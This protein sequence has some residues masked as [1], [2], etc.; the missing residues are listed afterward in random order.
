MKRN[1]YFV[2]K[3][4]DIVLFKDAIGDLNHG[5]LLFDA[6]WEMGLLWYVKGFYD[7]ESFLVAVGEE[8]RGS[9]SSYVVNSKVFVEYVNSRAKSENESI[10]DYFPYLL[11]E[12]EK[13]FLLLK[14][15]LDGSN[16]FDVEPRLSRML[17]ETDLDDSIKL[18]DIESPF[19]D[20]G[21]YI[22]LEECGCIYKKIAPEEYGAPGIEYESQLVGA[23]A[24]YRSPDE[25]LIPGDMQSRALHGPMLD[26]RTIWALKEPNG[27]EVVYWV[28]SFELK[29]YLFRAEFADLSLNEW[30]HEFWGNV[31]KSLGVFDAFKLVV[32]VL[33]YLQYQDRDVKY[34]WPDDIPLTLKK[35]LQGKKKQQEK[36]EA[37]LKKRGYS[38]IHFCG[39]QMRK[40]YER[41]YT[42]TG[43][44]VNPHWRRGHWRNQACGPGMKEHKLVWIKPMIVRRD[45][46][47]PEYGHIYQ[48]G[49]T[50]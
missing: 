16:I 33:L 35:S 43:R 45:K 17:N 2:D 15:Q 37:I 40:E 29:P 21:V 20:K 30:Y 34:R 12:L 46:G 41:L 50:A 19:P 23:F 42:E 26:I 22:N 44:E 18:A 27:H 10:E 24:E 6:V 31:D 28:Y 5:G 48:V 1:K 4:P 25:S 13:M 38:K 14:F 11:P 49:G 8:R 36:A 47:E 32:N 39:Y 7:Y 9:D 3:L